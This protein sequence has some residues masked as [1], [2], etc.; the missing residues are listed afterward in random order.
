MLLQKLAPP[1]LP[2][3]PLVPSCNLSSPAFKGVTRGIRLEHTSLPPVTPGTSSCN[4]V[5]GAH[6]DPGKPGNRYLD[7][8]SLGYSQN[9]KYLVL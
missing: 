7:L 8:E 2:R 9:V 1:T 6:Q 3:V 4:L 5:P